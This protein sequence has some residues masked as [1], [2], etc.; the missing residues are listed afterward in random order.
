MRAIVMRRTGDPEVLQVEEV[1]V[2]EPARGQ[3]L[4]RTEAV[5]INFFETRVRSGAALPMHPATL[6]VVPGFEAA[7]TVAAVGEG[8]DAALVGT[9][10]AT[11][12]GSGAYAEYVVAPAAAALPLPDGLSAAAAVAV[13]VQ[14]A[15]A[16]AVLRAAALSG[17][18]DV[19]IEAAGGGV[20]GYL[21]QLAR[22]FGVR[23]VTATAGSEAKRRLARDLGADAV[24]DHRD[25]DWPDQVVAAN[26]GARLDVVFE[27]L[28]GAAA[29][30]LLDALVPGAGRMVFYGL[31]SGEPPAIAPMD[32][33]LRGLSLIACGGRPA[34]YATGI[35]AGWSARVEAARPEALDRAADGRIRPLIDSEIP[36]A[37]AATA[38][39]RI[40]QREAVGKV[41][42]VP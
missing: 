5:G 13:A 9:R 2:P 22:E 28:G 32:L 15:T 24:L 6:P 27:S 21:L 31:S 36:L 11:V 34:D 7:G 20:G 12:G 35:A 17:G 41:V 3:V 33:L 14:G 38:H 25:P 19:L 40:E 37:D 4:V 23:R 16:L 29:R 42:L 30:R 10:V 8:V 18:E 39:C 26:R 1:P